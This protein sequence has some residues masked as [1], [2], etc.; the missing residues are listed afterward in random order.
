MP[1]E[2][3]K[4]VQA[5]INGYTDN[6]QQFLNDDPDLIR[7]RSSESHRATLLHY[8]GANGVEN[9]LRKTP[10]NAVDV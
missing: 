10:P 9:E 5:G 6:L 7:A 1:N 4:A 3:D 2:F 8:L